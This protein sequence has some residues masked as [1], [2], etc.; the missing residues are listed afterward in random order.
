MSNIWSYRQTITSDQTF[1]AN[2]LVGFDVEAT[3]GSIG[4]IDEASVEAD[5]AHIVVDTG[6]WIFGKKRLVPAGAVKQIDHAEGKVFISLTKDEVKEAPDWD[7]NWSGDD[8]TR[9][10]YEGYYGPYGW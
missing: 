10:T 6:F 8:D 2:A 9:S 5:R 1:D 3:D 4:K 7:A